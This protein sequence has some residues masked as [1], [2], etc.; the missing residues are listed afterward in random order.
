MKS[1]HSAENRRRDSAS[2]EA[3]SDDR[4]QFMNSLSA[5]IVESLSGS[6]PGQGVTKA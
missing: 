5:F 2:T 3:L 6:S 1:I 4:V